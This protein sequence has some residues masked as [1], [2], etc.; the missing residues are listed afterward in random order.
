MN[1]TLEITLSGVVQGV[2]MRFFINRTAN[3]F[4]ITGYVKNLYNNNVLAVLQGDEKLLDNMIVYIKKN[5]PGVIDTLVCNELEEENIYTKFK[6][7]LF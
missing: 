1:K 7:K 3:R 5:S 2:G 6:V 4:G